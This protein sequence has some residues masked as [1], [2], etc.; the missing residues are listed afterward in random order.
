[1]PLVP[2]VE[3][4]QGLVGQPPPEIPVEKGVRADQQ[5][6]LIRWNKVFIAIIPY[7]FKC[8]VPLVW[9]MPPGEDNEIFTCPTCGRVWVEE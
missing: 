2:G 8:K 6:L 9:H 3:T 4:I 7:C 1:M 5:R